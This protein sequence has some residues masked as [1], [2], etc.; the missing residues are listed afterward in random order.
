MANKV[1]LC[2]QVCVTVFLCQRSS[3]S[4]RKRRRTAAKTMAAG[5]K[6]M[7]EK[8]RTAGRPSQVNTPVHTPGYTF[9]TPLHTH[10]HTFIIIRPT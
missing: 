4:E 9:N 6:S 5:K 2:V 3:P 7:R 8:E 1:C 10:V